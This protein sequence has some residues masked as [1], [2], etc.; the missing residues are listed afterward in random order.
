MVAISSEVYLSHVRV[1]CFS[2][3]LVTADAFQFLLSLMR[4]RLKLDLNLTLNLQRSRVHFVASTFSM[5]L[6]R[7][8]DVITRRNVRLQNTV[9]GRFLASE[10]MEPKNEV[11]DI[12]VADE[13]PVYLDDP[14]FQEELAKKRNKSRLSTEHRNILMGERPYAQPMA[15]YHNKVRYKKRMLGRYGFKGNDEPVGFAWPT[16]KE[17]RDAQEYERVAFPLSI[18]E[19]W[20]KLEEAKRIK[21]EQ[22][23]ARHVFVNYILSVL[24]A[25]L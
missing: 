16:L 8:C 17:V 5:N 12:T 11:V 3:A 7:I 14:Q 2:R 10:S 9:L 24:D 13:K 21:A 15:H 23:Q 22:V 19:R 6:R 18:Q 20:K 1:V 4:L 25:S